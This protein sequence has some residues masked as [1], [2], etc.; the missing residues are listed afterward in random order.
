MQIVNVCAPGNLDYYDSYGLI[1][2]QLARHLAAMG[3]HPNALAL[4][5]AQHPN[6]PP[7][8]AAVT[9]R[10]I[11]PALG[12]ILLG[13]PSNYARYPALTQVGPR[14]ALTMFESSK[15][16]AGWVE[17]LNACDAVIVPSTFCREVFVRCGVTV[18][19]HVIALGVGDIYRYQPRHPVRPFTFL[20]FLDRGK[21]KG[22]AYALQAFLKAFGDNE[23]VRLLLK[24]R[25]PKVAVT[26]T[27]PNIDLI[28]RDMT[29]DELY[30]LYL[31]SDCL[32]NPNMGE[33]WG[34]IPREFAATGGISLTTAW[35]GTADDLPLW[36]VPLPYTLVEADWGDNPT[37]K[38]QD[39]GMWALPDIEGVAATMR[40]VYEERDAYRAFAREASARVRMLYSWRR[41]AQQVYDV[42][43]GVADGKRDRLSA[44]A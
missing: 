14:V 31:E 43:K 27:N 13:Y 7:D 42:W 36:G 9:A 41:F 26:L 33:G 10:P 19:V 2:C 4:G 15:I 35:G 22:G 37:L 5:N 18:P 17:P 34:L 25:K 12:G 21:R 38:G 30:A 20:A 29:E 32:V 16:P 1:A 8:V 11:Q 23:D 6:Q 28:Q 3:V 40:Q 39:L 44:T 24:Q